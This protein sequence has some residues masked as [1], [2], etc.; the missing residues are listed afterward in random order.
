MYACM[1]QNAE[2][3]TELIKHINDINVC[4]SDGKAVREFLSIN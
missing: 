3:V 2:F 1:S 4:D